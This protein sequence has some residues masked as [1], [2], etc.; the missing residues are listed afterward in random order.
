LHLLIRN[1][2]CLLPFLLLTRRAGTGSLR[3]P[4]SPQESPFAPYAHT[5]RWRSSRNSALF[6]ETSRR[7]VLYTSRPAPLQRAA[8]PAVTP[9]CRRPPEATCSAV[10]RPPSSAADRPP[11]RDPLGAD[12]TRPSLCEKW[13]PWFRARCHPLVRSRRA[14]TAPLAADSTSGEWPPLLCPHALAKIKVRISL[15]ALQAERQVDTAISDENPLAV[16]ILASDTLVHRQPVYR[17]VQT[18][19]NSRDTADRG[20][21][22]GLLFSASCLRPGATI[23][24]WMTASVPFEVP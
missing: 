17:D 21:V 24:R 16:A 4:H 7:T 12:I 5:C 9:P 8:E 14:H 19:C 10:A 6:S 1:Q 3:T 20:L 11:L 13:L 23:A 2:R 15:R 22:A 18:P